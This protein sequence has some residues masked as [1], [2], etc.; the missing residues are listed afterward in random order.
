MERKLTILATIAMIAAVASITIATTT[1]ATTAYAQEDQSTT[2]GAKPVN[3]GGQGKQ[4]K[5]QNIKVMAVIT[6]L[7]TSKGVVTLTG[8][9]TIQ[10]QTVTKTISVNASDPSDN[11]GIGLPLFFKKAFQPCPPLGTAF[12][13]SVNQTTFSGILQSLKSPNFVDVDLSGTGQ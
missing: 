5:C 9:A 3:P 12:S 2:L 11:D 4:Q 7:D 13:G 1:I 6:G 10:D 8:S